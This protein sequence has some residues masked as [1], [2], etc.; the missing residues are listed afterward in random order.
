M[1]QTIV[2][3]SYQV[4]NLIGMITRPA[5]TKYNFIFPAIYNIFDA[6]CALIY[7]LLINHLVLPCFPS[8]TMKKRLGIGSLINI[9]T[10]ISAA[11]VQWGTGASDSK[12]VLLWLLIPG[13][14]LPLGEVLMFV[15]GE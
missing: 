12:H 3:M 8:L 5:S 2:M 13:A 7:L 1:L 14:L 4:S 15:T 11:Y 10:L 6:L 9:V